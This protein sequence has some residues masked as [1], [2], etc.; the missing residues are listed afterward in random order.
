[1]NVYEYIIAFQ[2][3]VF[4]LLPQPNFAICYSFTSGINTKY[5][6]TLYDLL[7]VSLS[8]FL[9]SYLSPATFLSLFFLIFFYFRTP[10]MRHHKAQ[11]RP[12]L[13][14]AIAPLF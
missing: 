7:P 14:R 12:S 5:T 13:D 8:L 3:Y 6:S 11:F 10:A 9:T 1:M 4:V 2:L